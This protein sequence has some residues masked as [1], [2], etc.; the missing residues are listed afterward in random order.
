M[1]EIHVQS[2]FIVLQVQTATFMVEIACMF[3]P[4]KEWDSVTTVSKCILIL[5]AAR[6][7]SLYVAIWKVVMIANPAD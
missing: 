5:L 3:L 1:C 7:C 2:V 4:N 6:V